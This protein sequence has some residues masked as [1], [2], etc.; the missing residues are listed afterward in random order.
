MPHELS[1]CVDG[2]LRDER[3]ALLGDAIDELKGAGATVYLDAGNPAS[4]PTSTRS[5]VR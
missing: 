5:P 1:G 2:E 3:Y 4:S